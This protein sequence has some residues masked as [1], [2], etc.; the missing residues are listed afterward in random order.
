[1]RVVILVLQVLI[2][3][4]KIL[5]HVKSALLVVSRRK[6]VP[7]TA[8]LALLVLS[9]TPPVLPNASLAQPRTKKVWLNALLLRRLL[10]DL[11]VPTLLV[12]PLLLLLLPLALL[13]LLLLLVPLLPLPPLPPL[14]RLLLLLPQPVHLLLLQLALVLQLLLPQLELVHVWSLL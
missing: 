3:L 5:K 13:L 9:K 4:L 12:L 6:V 14:L 11:L 7:M 8:F 1:V 10:L 2:L